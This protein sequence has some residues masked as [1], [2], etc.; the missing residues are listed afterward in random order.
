MHI[1]SLSRVKEIDDQ[2]ELI[3]RCVRNRED[4]NSYS[5]SYLS[6]GNIKIVMTEGELFEYMYEQKSRLLKELEELGVN[7]GTGSYILK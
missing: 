6:H 4:T 5:Q 7:V 3:R 2:L 1:N